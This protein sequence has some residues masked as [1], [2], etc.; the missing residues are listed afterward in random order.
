SD[1]SYAPLDAERVEAMVAREIELLASAGKNGKLPLSQA[2]RVQEL[3]SQI[4]DAKV[5]AATKQLFK[6][7]SSIDEIKQIKKPRALKATLRP[8]QEQGLSW[9]KF[10]HDLGT[11]GIL[12]DD[13]GLGKTIETI[14]L[15]LL[16]KQENKS[17]RALIVA[18]TSV[19]G[20]WVREIER[21]APT[22]TTALWHG[23]ARKEQ[24]KDLS[25]VNVI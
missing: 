13:M 2:G 7:L 8:Y 10:V 12:A 16:V 24:Q 1:D 22:L 3:L 9:L 19:V 14:A 6:K 18:P 15:L 25:S 21:F 20:N 23:A 4:P 11:G 17:L 5:T